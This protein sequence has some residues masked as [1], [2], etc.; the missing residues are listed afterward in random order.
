MSIEINKKF[1]GRKEINNMKKLLGLLGTIL[2]TGNVIPSVIAAAPNIK[3]NIK[4]RQNNENISTTPKMQD[5]Q[6]S[7]LLTTSDSEF[8]IIEKEI[9]LNENYSDNI[10][11]II[12]ELIKNNQLDP[13]RMINNEGIIRTDYFETQDKRNERENNIKIIEKLDEILELKKFDANKIRILVLTLKNKENNEIKLIINLDNF[14][15]QGF[16]NKNNQY[17][18]FKEEKSINEWKQ[19]IKNLTEELNEWNKINEEIKLLDLKKLNNSQHIINKIDEI[20]ENLKKQ[21]GGKKYRE[22]KEKIDLLNKNLFYKIQINNEDSESISKLNELK[23]KIETL[24]KEKIYLNKIQEELNAYQKIQKIRQ[25]SINLLNKGK[26]KSEIKKESE[27]NIKKYQWDNLFNKI[28]SIIE[29]NINTI[30]HKKIKENKINEEIIKK[31]L[32]NKSKKN[33]LNYNGSYQDKGLNTVNQNIDITKRNLNSAIKN[34]SFL[35]NESNQNQTTKDDLAKIIF[36]TSEAMRFGSYLKYFNYEKDSKQVEFKNIQENIQNIINSTNDDK[37][38]WKDY[39]EQLIGGWIASS[40]YVEEKRK[41]IFEKLSIEINYFELM[42]I[43]FSDKNKFNKMNLTIDWTNNNKIRYDLLFQVLD[44]NEDEINEI[45][46][47]DFFKIKEKQLYEQEKIV[48]E[49]V[50]KMLGNISHSELEKKQNKLWNLW[51]FR[52]KKIMLRQLNDF[53]N[54]EKIKKLKLFY[55][56]EWRVEDLNLK[57]IIFFNSLI[58]ENYNSENKDEIKNNLDFLELL[59]WKFINVINTTNINVDNP[60]HITIA[61]SNLEAVELLLENGVNVNSKNKMG[62]T[63]LLFAIIFGQNQKNNIKIIKKLIEY[64]ADINISDENNWTPFIWSIIE[65]Y[66]EAVQILI[67]SGININKEK[68]EIFWISYNSTTNEIRNILNEKISKDFVEEFFK[69]EKIKLPNKDILKIYS[70]FAKE[71]IFNSEQNTN[72]TDLNKKLDFLIK[73]IKI[74]KK[75][76]H[77]SNINNNVINIK[78]IG[79]GGFKSGFLNKISKFE[80]N[81]NSNISVSDH[82]RT[83]ETQGLD[84]NK[85]Q[86]NTMYNVPSDNS[87]LFWSVATAYLLSIRN[88]NEEFKNRFIKLFGEENLKYLQLIQKLLKQYDLENNRNLNQLWYQNQIANNLVTNVFRNRVVDYIRGNLDNSTQINSQINQIETFRSAIQISENEIN[89]NNYLERMRQ[90]SSWGGQLEILAIGNLL[91]SNINVNNRNIFETNNPNANLQIFHVNENHYNFILLQNTNEEN[92]INSQEKNTDIQKQQKLTKA[93]KPKTNITILNKST[94]NNNTN[95]SVNKPIKINIE[96]SQE[97]TIKKAINK[98]NTLSKEEKQQKLNEINQHY[99]SL[100]ENEQKAFKDK[101][102]DVSLGLTSTGISGAGILGISKM[103]GISPIKGLSTTDNYIKNS[104]STTRTVVSSETGEA[105][106]M[107]PLLSESTVA[108]G[109][110]AAET[111]SAIEG[112]AF[113]A[114]EGAVIGTEAGTAAALAPETLGLSLVIGGLLI[115]GTAILWWINSDHTIVKHES[116]NQYNEIEKY[117]KFLAHD[118]LKLDININEWNKIKQIYQENANNYQEFKNKI[119]SEI[120][121]FHKKDHS[122]WGGSINDEDINTLINII[123]NHFEEINNHFLSNPNHGWKII[124]NTIGNYFIIEEE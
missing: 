65:K 89:I 52:I 36:I 43:I 111:L 30:E 104:L 95:L 93:E 55:K 34:L 62:Q 9:I 99:Q 86:E 85:K 28:T 13:L 50:K 29:S 63:P 120:T 54:N 68:N 109:L 83:S 33:K 110:T 45:L 2:V 18:Y 37:I 67:N 26:L 73:K 106:E 15:L 78:N 119:K 82:P 12:K 122:G 11:K 61:N 38:Q 16:I 91:G 75:Q 79:F 74:N 123:Y 117:Y 51:K 101:L 44:K 116:H 97:T 70:K 76:P 100:P 40:K 3:H 121:N 80:N 21:W 108:E 114:T 71:L 17:F 46:F 94:V 8:D 47:W 87:C 81:S 105:V 115:A 57:P 49:E 48:K 103:T 20:K 84:S 60:L 31:Y 90:S 6:N 24:N 19:E 27:E 102:R 32:I 10:Q 35:D 64:N 88:N 25:T 41:E 7:E 98:Y 72:I 113:V 58:N 22:N 4:K 14:Y 23:E 42:K 96:N 77:T 107:T 92:I 5:D 39:S 66:E 59:I 56:S 112:S 118:Q 69:K 124:T 53:K 1:Q